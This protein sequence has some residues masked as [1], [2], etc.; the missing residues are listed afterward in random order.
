MDDL[1][2]RRE[3]AL[4]ETSSPLNTDAAIHQEVDFPGSPS[5]LYEALLDERQFGALTCAP[6]EIQAEA[7]GRFSLFG[8]RVTGR[9]VELVP[10]QRIVQAWRVEAWP[11]GVYSLVRFELTEQDSGTHL[12]LDQTGFPPQDRGALDGNWPRMYWEPLRRHVGAGS[13][14]ALR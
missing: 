13:D 3:K 2:H 1:R 7:G 9:H 8:G 4:Q 11:P 5:R 6:A 10:G 12:V 14:T